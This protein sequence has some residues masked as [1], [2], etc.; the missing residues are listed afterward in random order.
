[1]RESEMCAVIDLN[2]PS[3]D[4][5][6]LTNERPVGTMPFAG[7]YRLVDFPLSAISNA[8]IRTAGIFLPRSSRSVEDHIRSGQAWDLDTITG[9]V[10]SF[11][12]VATRDYSDPVNIHRYYD[13]YL[14]FLI[15]SK[16]RYVFITGARNVSNLDVNA[17]LQFHQASPNPISAVYRSV[18]TTM[19][20]PDQEGF[21]LGEDNEVIG[22]A[23][24][25]ELP[26]RT[27]DHTKP[28]SM[29]MYLT[30]TDYLI[31]LLSRVQN[32]GEFTRLPQLL[33]EEIVSA[34]ANAF[35]YTG[36]CATIHDIQSYYQA[37]MD[38][39]NE[40]NF[41]ALLFSQRA[42][43]T[44]NK[45]EAPTY[46]APEADVLGSLLG[47]GGQIEGQVRHSVLF[48]NVTVEDGAHVAD[49]IVM[50]SSHIG[51]N[52]MLSCVIMDKGCIVG[53][54]VKLQGTS[55][56]PIVLAK[57]TTILDQA[58]AEEVLQS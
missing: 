49:S 26:E 50:Q 1:M 32:S 52:A 19:A 37:N 4:L 41:H 31:E 34:Q 25:H 24:S 16:S 13:N 2:E 18:P 22:F 21:V 46:F 28:I 14:T 53:P 29:Q 10:F 5:A 44:K 12:Y 7:R 30:R 9:G 11:P 40:E 35:E 42:I 8:G 51:K 45:N 23:P 36:Y 38:M 47:T 3:Q 39:L 27:S 6:P 57:G 17:L 15:K 55:S 20:D 58:A 54:N 33:H 43:F 48:R 56:A